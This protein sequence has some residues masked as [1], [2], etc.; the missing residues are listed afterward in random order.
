MDHSSNAFFLICSAW[1]LYSGQGL[2][3]SGMKQNAWNMIP[4]LTKTLQFP[5]IAYSAKPCTILFLARSSSKR[6]VKKYEGIRHRRSDT[7][8]RSE[9]KTDQGAVGVY[10]IICAFPPYLHIL[11]FTGLLP[12]VCFS[13]FCMSSFVPRSCILDSRLQNTVRTWVAV[14]SLCISFLIHRKF[15]YGEKGEEG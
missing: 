15:R 14:D 3:C 10:F 5:L 4:F 7:K 12:L 11:Y 1:D 8:R 2:G 13:P 6:T 9:R